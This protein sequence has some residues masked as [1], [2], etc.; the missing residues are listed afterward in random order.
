MTAPGAAEHAKAVLS[1]SRC[2]V[3]EVITFSEIGFKRAANRSR[4]VL[5]SYIAVSAEHMS[6]SDAVQGIGSL[7]E[8]LA[9]RRRSWDRCVISPTA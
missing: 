2:A 8:I 4:G 1:S 3:L 6:V 5:L 9:Q 7:P